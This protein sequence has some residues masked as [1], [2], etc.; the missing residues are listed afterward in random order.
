MLKYLLD[1]LASCGGVAE[2]Q[3]RYWNDE[4][5]TTR[6]AAA[7]ETGVVAVNEGVDTLVRLIPWTAI[8]NISIKM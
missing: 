3:I 7:D 6:A 2:V 1:Y 5:V 4:M 8:R